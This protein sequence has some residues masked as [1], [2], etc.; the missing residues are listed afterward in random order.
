M[1][2]WSRIRKGAQRPFANRS[3][4][5]R[6]EWG[7]AGR[8]RRRNRRV[9]IAGGALLGAV[10][11][12]FGV[13]FGFFRGGGGEGKNA[14]DHPQPKCESARLHGK[15]GVLAWSAGGRLRTLDLDT[16][17]RD[18]AVRRHAP[19]PV[20]FS[21][22]GKHIAFGDGA[23]VSAGGGPVTHPIGEV[24][25]W[26]WS[27]S[28][29]LAGVTKDGKVVVGTLKGEPSTIVA[30]HA[31]SVEFSPDSR[32]LAVGLDNRVVV[33][34]AD[35]GAEKTLYSGPKHDT[36]E[37]AGWSPGGN[38]VLFWVHAPDAT[39]AP[40]DAAPVSGAGYHNVFDPVLPYADFMSWCGD[41]LAVAGGGDK[42]ASEGQQLLTSSAPAWSTHNLS[43]DFR[44]SWIW[45]A[46]SPDGTRIA[47]TVT[48][49][50]FEDPQGEGRRSVFLIDAKGQLRRRLAGAPNKA[51]ET[52]R[53]SA[54]GRFVMVIERAQKAGSPGDVIFVL[55]DPKTGKPVKTVGPIARLGRSHSPEGHTDWTSTL[56]WYRPS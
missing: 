19:P 22:D 56:D 41:T 21:R 12:G 3:A 24:A 16:C 27:P 45:P 18:I 14:A 4:L 9:L 25:S 43:R 10:A 46:C 50:H 40:L 32:Q 30:R 34:F 28:G 29:E 5:R 54:D 37:I 15:L 38:W 11:I 51:Y 33:T 17:A 31:T 48:P 8:H 53:W 1:S 2:R 36:V 20:R 42:Y 44:S 49:N 55:V 13:W 7:Q 23:V 39:S 35:G 6:F 47:V 26:T 52:P